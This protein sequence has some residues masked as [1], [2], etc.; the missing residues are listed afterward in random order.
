[1]MQPHEVG[2]DATEVAVDGDGGNIALPQLH[3]AL[4]N[5]FLAFNCTFEGPKATL[6]PNGRSRRDAEQVPSFLDELFRHGN[7]PG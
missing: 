7:P 2:I 6:V 1:M 5:L 4:P 3:N